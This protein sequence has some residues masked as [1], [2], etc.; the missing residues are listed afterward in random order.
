M[1]KLIKISLIAI[2]LLTAVK[3]YSQVLSP[4]EI[5]EKVNDAVV[6][7]IAYDFNN[8]PKNQGSGV[9]LNEQGYVVTNYHVFAGCERLEIKHYDK[10]IPYSDI[11]GIDVEK[12]LL[13]LKIEDNIFPSIQLANVDELKVGQR[14]YAIGSP[15]GFENSMSEG[16]ISGLRN[17]YMLERNFIQI[18][19]GISSGSSGGAVVN[20]E[21]ELIGIS[22]FTIK[23]G[24][25]LNFAI[26]VS[27]ILSLKI[28]SYSDKD[29]IEKY[30]LFYKGQNALESGNYSASIKYYDEFIKKNPDIAVAY[31]NRGI[32]YYQLQ[33][34][35][36]A[37]SD[38]THAIIIDPDYALAYHNRAI[39]YYQ[40]QRYYDAISNF[41]KSISVD[42]PYI[43]EAY[44][45][46]GFVYG[47]LKKYD[48][49]LL[50]Y[51][52]AISIDSN[53]ADAYLNRGIVYGILKKY[54]KALLDY[55]KVISIEPNN[56]YAYYSRGLTYGVMEEYDKAISN[57][58]KAISIDPNLAVAYCYRGVAYYLIGECYNAKKDMEKA[59]E[60]EHSYESKLR[61][62]INNCK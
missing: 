36:E 20:S 31:Y 52:K 27:D 13:I 11:I 48:K 46:R 59:I 6:V 39:A 60:L 8:E 23:D 16:I 18:T 14:I 44:N 9:V 2:F 26:P 61:T 41:T 34:Y 4:E 15:L 42:N 17:V 19:A 3:L 57:H 40:L 47:I 62:F 32:A 50:D 5:Y 28:G 54:D 58:T 45:K 24:Q 56:A 25:N 33:K 29:S 37:V 12:D 55:T 49:A 51:T 30:N 38:L 10:T 35:E 21:G 22:T 53:Y 7:I 43:V 1:H